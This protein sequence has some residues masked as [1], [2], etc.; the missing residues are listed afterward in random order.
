MKIDHKII[1][2]IDKHHLLHLSTVDNNKPYNANCFYS[3]NKNLNCFYISSDPKTQHGQNMLKNPNISASIA[4]E[5][6][7]I[8]K[9]QGLQITGKAIF[10]END[11]QAKKSYLKKFPYALAMRLDLWKL[12]VNFYKLTDNNLGFG[13]KLI[14]RNNESDY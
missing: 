2:F 9:I 7:I 10:I 4:L 3:Y 11:Q 13:K 5:T 14:W 6:N 8:G 12:D 1:S